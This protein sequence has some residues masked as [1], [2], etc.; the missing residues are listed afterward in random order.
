MNPFKKL[1][2]RAAKKAKQFF[3]DIKNYPKKRKAEIAKQIKKNKFK[4]NPKHFKA[5]NFLTFRYNA[6]DQTKK[7]DKN[8]LIIS[9]GNPKDNKKHILGLNIHWMKE[10]QRVLLASLIVEIKDK[11]GGKVYY[12]DIKPLIKKFEGS[13]ILRRYAVR[14]ISQTIIQ[15]PEDQYL[16][17]AAISYPE[18]S[19]GEK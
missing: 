8:P 7:F 19:Y 5:G 14:R 1:F 9:L 16:A 12:E 4:K 3:K 18:W 10:S 2:S 11:N 6:I 17:A 15:M 13:P